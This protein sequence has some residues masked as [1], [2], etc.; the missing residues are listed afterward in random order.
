LGVGF[1]LANQAT[2]DLGG[3]WKACFGISWA[4]CCNVRI[5]VNR[6][7][8]EGR[9]EWKRWMDFKDRRLFF[10]VVDSGLVEVEVA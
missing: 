8:D 7:M 1:L 5:V 10:K 9:G 4:N 3:F 2:A 6:H